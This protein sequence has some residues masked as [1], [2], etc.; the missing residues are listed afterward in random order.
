ML[1]FHLL[2]CFFPRSL[3]ELWRQK[4]HAEAAASIKDYEYRK[5]L[6]KKKDA[7]EKRK[8]KLQGVCE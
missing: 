8:V 7:E 6:K 5:S 3:E 2:L 4:Q 1:G